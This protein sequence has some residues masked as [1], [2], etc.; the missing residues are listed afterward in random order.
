M[1]HEQ[2]VLHD[3]YKNVV[4]ILPPKI[5]LLSLS[6]FILDISNSRLKF[7]LQSS[8]YN[9]KQAHNS[10]LPSLTFYKCYNKLLIY[11]QNWLADRKISL[12]KIGNR[13]IE[14]K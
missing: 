12:K 8:S 6:F 10:L 11:V 7:E 9:Y 1:L 2:E 4:M 5:F 13:Y 3:A 14:P